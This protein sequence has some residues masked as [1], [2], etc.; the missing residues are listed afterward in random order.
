MMAWMNR[1]KCCLL[2]STFFHALSACVVE[3]RRGHERA[4]ELG[5]GNMHHEGAG[6]RRPTTNRVKC[7]RVSIKHHPQSRRTENEI[8][9]KKINKQK[10]T[11][12]WCEQ[13]ACG[14]FVS[15]PFQPLPSTTIEI[16]HDILL[17][18]WCIIA[19]DIHIVALRDLRAFCGSSNAHVIS[20]AQ[21][22]PI[23]S[24]FYFILSSLCVS[25]QWMCTCVWARVCVCMEASRRTTTRVLLNDYDQ[26]TN[27]RC[28]F[29]S[30]AKRSCISP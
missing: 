10:Y 16:V 19:R 12:F 7:E 25:W 9:T 6:R 15:V 4:R 23:Y 1:Q 3:S 13:S 26:S 30:V 8:H 28:K 24:S 11:T 20:P 17:V 21:P 18:H 22:I 2:I 29:N 27:C 14:L 5:M